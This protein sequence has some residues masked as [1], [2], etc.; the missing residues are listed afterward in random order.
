MH[1]GN[2]TQL[3]QILNSERLLQS[4][5]NE[6]N[7]RESQQKGN[8]GERACERIYSRRS[9]GTTTNSKSKLEVDHKEPFFALRKT[10]KAN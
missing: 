4:Y 8:P 10:K 5:M 7:T 6:N 3:Y 1:E 9:T 2:A